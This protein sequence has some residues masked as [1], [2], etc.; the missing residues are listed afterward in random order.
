MKAL[1]S[2]IRG[3][4]G[5]A[6]VRLVNDA[7]KAQELQVDLLADESQDAVERL[8]NYG[9][10]AHPHRGAEAV[11]ICASGLRS[12]M[13]VIA[14][15]D[16]RFRLTGLAE[17]EVALYD[18]LGNLVKL[19]RDRIE[20]VAVNELAITAPLVAIDGTV[21]ATGDV[22]ANGISLTGH[23]HGGVQAGGANT[24]AAL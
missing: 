18:D 8:Q 16:R 2:R 23:H 11:A 6:I 22:I 21:T 1:E 19:G 14:V 17:G 5:R 7:T 13:I 3:M 10:T 4:I 20:I 15:E 9:F 12:H 24:G